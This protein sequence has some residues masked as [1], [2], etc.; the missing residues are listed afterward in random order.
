MDY[1]KCT[2][3][4]NNI[5][6]SA[7]IFKSLKEMASSDAPFIK[8][9]VYI[10]EEKDAIEYQK[11]LTF[12]FEANK[13]VSNTYSIRS[14]EDCIINI[15]RD[16]LSE[17]TICKEDDIKDLYKTVLA[18]PITDLEIIYI[19]KGVKVNE[20]KSALGDFTIYKYPD[21]IE[22]LT[23]KYP[24]FWQHN[25]FL[26]DK[27]PETLLGIKVKARENNKIVEIADSLVKTFENTLNY[28][29]AD[30]THRRSIGI[31]TYRPWSNVPRITCYENKGIGYYGSNIPSLPITLLLSTSEEIPS[32][33][34]ILF[35]LI[36]KVN[37]TE[38]ER[39]VLNAVEWAGKACID[40]DNSKALMQFVFALESLLQ[41]NEGSFIVPSIISQMSDWS[42]FIISDDASERKEI[43]GH[44]KHIYNKR[45]AIAHG[46]KTNIEI[47]DLVIAARLVKRIV[48]T[49]LC[50][51]PYCK[52]KTMNEVRNHIETL[53][54]K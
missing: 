8:S 31:F 23:E 24:T 1:R 16:S 18:K 11:A 30:L 43:A 6:K 50:T 51:E 5:I 41:Y 3:L 48:R 47:G 7:N 28:E 46:G 40:L 15:I 33:R 29:I 27:N 45:S 36:T 17:N 19:L 10:A 39:R 42:A 49:F 22:L 4:I 12:L 35:E 20:A 13:E 38:I 25:T 32:E 52:M 21:C 2:E 14:F 37:K 44:F 53:K 26:N 9:G 54:F 34:K